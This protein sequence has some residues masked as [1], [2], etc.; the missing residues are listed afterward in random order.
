MKRNLVLLLFAACMIFCGTSVRAEEDSSLDQEIMDSL[1]VNDPQK[2]LTLTNTA[3]ERNPGNTF[4][5]GVRSQMF[6]QLGEVDKALNDIDAILGKEVTADML[7]YRCMVRES[8]AKVTSD[9][10]ECYA[11][12]AQE[13]ERTHPR[14]ELIRKHGYIML[15]LMAGSPNA[16]NARKEH[17]AYLQTKND[18][19][20]ALSPIK[21]FDRSEIE[22]FIESIRA[23]QR[24]AG[25][26]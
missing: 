26:R 1:A 20:Y 10:L 6:L 25:R 9:A 15:L 7:L 11:S 2:T 3:I 19:E 16:E 4:A 23:A 8:Q 21:D 14:S 22:P 13:L 24:K 5:L 18:N 12:A 17:L